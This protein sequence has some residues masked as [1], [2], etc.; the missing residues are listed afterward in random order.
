[1]SPD[2][3]EVRAARRFGWTSL[4][5]WA[6]LGL[7][8]ETMHGFKVG[9]YLDDELGRMLLRL[10]HAHGVGLSLVVLVY[11][12]AGVPVL[13]TRPDGGRGIGRLI[14]AAALLIPLG[15]ALGAI[16]HPEGDPSL[17]VIL[18]PAGGALLLVALIAL[19]IA[20]WRS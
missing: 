19:A 13:A 18:V 6:A 20:S 9:L 3:L 5:C 4:A 15:F 12:F 14:R 10:A 11:A 7:G 2:A 1:M 17:L 16:G 8:L